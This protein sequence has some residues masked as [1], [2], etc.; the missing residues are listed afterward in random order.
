MPFRLTPGRPARIFAPVH[1]THRRAWLVAV[2]VLLATV[3]RAAD[4]PVAALKLSIVSKFQDFV[5]DD[6]I[7]FVAVD[8]A[9]TKGAGVDPEA[10]SVRFHVEY[11]KYYGKGIWPVAAGTVNGWLANDDVKA[12]YVYPGDEPTTSG[13][14]KKLLIRPGKLLKLNARRLGS[15]ETEINPDDTGNPLGPVYT[16]YCVTNGVEENCHCSEFQDCLWKDVSGGVGAKLV[17]RNGT[18]DASC[19]ASCS[20]VVDQGSTA[21]DNCSGLEWEKKD[22][23]PGSGPDALNLHD[24]DNLY[25]WAGRCTLDTT[26]LCQPDTASA[27]TCAAHVG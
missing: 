19:R 6:R 11:G 14:V 8:P 23:A 9:V 22:T 3:A 5:E 24:V 18:G 2:W 12:K 21:V 25:T 7:T 4:I 17:C 15:T 20:D 27:A 1:L 10:I 26:V 16:A 13:A